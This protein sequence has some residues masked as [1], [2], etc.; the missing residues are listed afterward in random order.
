MWP[1][2]H[3]VFTVARFHRVFACS[4]SFFRKLSLFQT[5]IACIY[6]CCLPHCCTYPSRF[7]WYHGS[8]WY[9]PFFKIIGLVT[10][11]FRWPFQTSSG[12]SWH[13]P[14]SQ[15]ADKASGRCSTLCLKKVSTFKLY[16]TLSN[17][18]RFQSQLGLV[19]LP[20]LTSALCGYVP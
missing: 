19:P 3:W 4:Y 16:V 15:A 6:V 10:T 9:V 2:L 17:L 12:M 8:G 7:C 13:W 20:S 5:F 18:D 14:I 1:P 11:L